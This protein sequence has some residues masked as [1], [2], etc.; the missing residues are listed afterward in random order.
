MRDSTKLLSGMVS[1]FLLLFLL[2]SHFSLTHL[3]SSTSTVHLLSISLRMTNNVKNDDFSNTDG[4]L[5]G[6]MR[7]MNKMAKR[8][9]GQWCYC[10][11]SLSSFSTTLYSCFSF[12]CFPLARRDGLPTFGRLHL[13]LDLGHSEVI[14][15]NSH[16]ISILWTQSDYQLPP[17]A[18]KSHI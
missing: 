18:D 10:A 8:Q 16:I 3:S 6:T 14:C 5:S 4:I 17:H 7:R 13:L 12:V 11:C 9:G 2:T 15:S 1:S